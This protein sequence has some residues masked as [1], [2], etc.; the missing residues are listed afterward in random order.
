MNDKIMLVELQALKNKMSIE[1]LVYPSLKKEELTEDFLDKFIEI[2]NKT[3][4]ANITILD[5]IIK[6]L[7]SKGA[8]K[9]GKQN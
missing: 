3:Y 7:E 8:E 4:D 9:D 6:Y 1:K 5:N 2:I